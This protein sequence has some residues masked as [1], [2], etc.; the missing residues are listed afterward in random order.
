MVLRDL[1]L[2]AEIFTRAGVAESADTT[3]GRVIAADS[4]KYR[5]NKATH[6]RMSA[7]HVNHRK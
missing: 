7:V 1:A 3:H 2:R 5:A 6:D 4:N